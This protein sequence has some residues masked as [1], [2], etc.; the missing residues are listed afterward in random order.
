[1]SVFKNYLLIFFMLTSLF[2]SGCREEEQGRPL[3]YD[4]GVYG[5]KADASLSAETVYGFRTRAKGQA[6]Y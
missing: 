6:W 1:M 5:G 4:K 2:L 3:S